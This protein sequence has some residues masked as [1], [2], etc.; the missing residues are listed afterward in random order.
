MN[1]LQLLFAMEISTMKIIISKALPSFETLVVGLFEND[2]FIS[3][4]KVLQDKQIIYNIK[5]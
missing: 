4:D 5:I 3:N 1:S 2:E